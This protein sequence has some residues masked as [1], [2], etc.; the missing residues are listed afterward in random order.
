MCIALL[1]HDKVNVQQEMNVG[2]AQRLF[3][4]RG[5]LMMPGG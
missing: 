3:E 1:P 5:R 4:L 2:R